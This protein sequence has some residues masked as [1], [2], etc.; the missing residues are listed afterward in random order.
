MKA[1]LGYLMNSNPHPL[2][3]CEDKGEEHCRAKLTEKQVIDIIER[4]DKGETKKSLAREYGVSPKAIR[5]IVKGEHWK[6]LNFRK[7]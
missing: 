6:H 7:I 4:L 5:F 3:G 2:R 1:I